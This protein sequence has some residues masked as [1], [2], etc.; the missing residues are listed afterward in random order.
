MTYL[1]VFKTIPRQFQLQVMKSGFLYYLSLTLICLTQ[2]AVVGAVLWL[3]GIPFIPEE[4][5]VLDYL[6]SPLA[7][8]QIVLFCFGVLAAVIVSV[9]LITY[10]NPDIPNRLKT[11]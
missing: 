3:L 8:V 5:W 11:N 6:P 7:I 9:L 1:L 4:T 2:V 10:L